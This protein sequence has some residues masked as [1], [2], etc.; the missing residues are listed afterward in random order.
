MPDI[1]PLRRVLEV[2]GAFGNSRA[3]IA[4][5]GRH[6]G[7]PI[8]GR[9]DDRAQG[10]FAGCLVSALYSWERILERRAILDRQLI[11]AGGE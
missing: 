7:P 6:G 9:V 4:P 5:R 2:I 10:T 3:P 1:S 8:A 11:R